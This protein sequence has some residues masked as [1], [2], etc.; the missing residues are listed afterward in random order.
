MRRFLFFFFLLATLS[1][2]AQEI[3]YDTIRVSSDDER[4]I[5]L[6]RSRVANVSQAPLQRERL[7]VSQNQ[8]SFFNKSKLR[9]GANLG[10]SVSSN[11]TNLGFGPQIGYQFNQYFMAGAGIKYYYSR[12]RTYEY[13]IKNNLL[14]ANLFGYLYPI[15]FIALFVQ[16]EINY[17]WSSLT[18]LS[19][20]KKTQ[21]WG[22]VPSLV[23]GGGFRIKRS[24]VTLN[25]D[26]L[27]RANSPHPEGLYL[28]VSV[29]F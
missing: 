20:N 24:H 11:Y 17:I 2:R 1:L 27:Q 7:P 14:G 23:A 19:T 13:E 8:N 3:T 5:H 26:L 28:G 29:F 4:N 9:F 12:A 18:E 16:P 22:L 21:S 15:S 25:Y 6:N 10:L